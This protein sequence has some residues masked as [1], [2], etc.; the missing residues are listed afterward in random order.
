MLS[1][2]VKTFKKN[3]TFLH[4]T[5]LEIDGMLFV[6]QLKTVV[7]MSGFLIEKAFI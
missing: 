1:L 6:R 7:A 2:F 4:H 3:L 5:K